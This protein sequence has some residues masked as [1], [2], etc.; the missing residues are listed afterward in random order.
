MATTGIWKIE[1]RLDHVLDYT[2]NIEKTINNSYGMERYKDLHNAV[3]YAEAHYKTEKQ[4]YVSSLNCSVETALEEMIITKIVITDGINEFVWIPVGEVSDGTNTYQINLSR[5]TFSTDG[6]PTDVGNA[7][8]DLH[9]QEETLSTGLNLGNT[10]AKDI[11]SFIESA[12]TNKG[13]YI[14]RYEA[15]DSVA[16][17]NRTSSS[18]KTNPMIIKKD[19]FVYNFV[20]QLQATE[21][22][23]N[24]YTNSNFESDLINSYAWDTAIIFI[25]TFGQSNYSRQRLSSSLSK[26]GIVEDEQLHINDMAGNTLE[27][28]TE[29]HSNSGYPNV[30]RGGNFNVSSSYTADR[31]YHSV[32]LSNTTIGFRTLLYITM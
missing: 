20:T 4:C 27:W 2:T 3:E 18:S 15:S 23:R 29:T 31:N 21:L 28:T 25:Q 8:I 6:T 30:P 5:Y 9:Y 16:T 10:I 7:A 32:S 26:T 14:G 17:Q 22:S 1:S 13:Y 11:E 19:G 24:M 12:K